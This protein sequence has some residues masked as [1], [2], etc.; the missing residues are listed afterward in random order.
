MKNKSLF[1]TFLNGFLKSI[2]VIGIVIAIGVISYKVTL[3]YYQV[4]DNLSENEIANSIIDIVSDAK[5]DK[6]SKN[7]IFQV[8]KEKKEI[9]HIV[10]E[11]FNTTTYNL[12]YITIP[13]QTKY[14]ISETLYQKL[15]VVNPEVPQIIQLSELG[16]YFSEK[17]MYAYGSLIIGDLLST[18]ISYYTIFNIEDYQQI[19]ETIK[20]NKVERFREEFIRELSTLNDSKLLK[21][22]IND[23]YKKIDSNLSLKNKLKYLNSY[24]KVNVDFIYFHHIFGKD[25]D[26]NFIVDTESTTQLISELIE[27]LSYQQSQTEIETIAKKQMI[28]SKGLNIQIL[29]SS[30]ISGLASAYKEKLSLEGFTVTKVGNYEGDS[31]TNT[32]III[33]EKGRGNDLLEFFHEAIIEIGEVPDG[34]D[35]QIILGTADRLS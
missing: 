22:Y 23:L 35:I 24:L 18:D 19:F 11:I 1:W 15:C 30:K 34:V 28:S 21:E 12:D 27:N 9:K 25:S 16:K 10:L 3:S 8:E 7:L 29:N 33:K 4:N 32:H 20:D 6:I 5:V 14:T 31:L 17:S 2:L 26:S 13:A